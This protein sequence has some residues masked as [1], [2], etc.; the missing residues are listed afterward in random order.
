MWKSSGQVKVNHNYLESNNLRRSVNQKTQSITGKKINE[1]NTR[2]ISYSNKL[3]TN[4]NTRDSRNADS[5]RHESRSGIRELRA[6]NKVC[7]IQRL[8]KH[9]TKTK[10][11]EENQKLQTK[12]LIHFKSTRNIGS[13]DTIIISSMM[14]HFIF[15]KSWRS[16]ACEFR[17]NLHCEKGFCDAWAFLVLNLWSIVLK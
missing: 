9:P 10:H 8:L 12:I 6:Q 17:K 2:S 3:S 11:N 14:A 1:D 7:S 5:G 16:L 13:K 4:A 15:A